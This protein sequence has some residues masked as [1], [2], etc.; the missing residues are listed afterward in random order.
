MKG[1]VKVCM[2]DW[3]VGFDFNYSFAASQS[4]VY[5]SYLSMKFGFQAGDVA[6][7]WW[8]NWDAQT[9]NNALKGVPEIMHN[10]EIL[11]L[12]YLSF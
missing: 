10:F 11:C 6:R 1:W 4:F 9:N 7:G 12:L 3:R 8:K 5:F 2:R